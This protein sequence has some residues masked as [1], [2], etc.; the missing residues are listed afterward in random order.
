[1]L[2]IVK[3]EK[4][5][6]LGNP[7]KTIKH[8]ADIAESALAVNILLVATRKVHLVL[9]QGQKKKHECKWKWLI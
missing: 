9:H 6:D 7:D 8:G 5:F 3:K 2:N 1:M 4:S